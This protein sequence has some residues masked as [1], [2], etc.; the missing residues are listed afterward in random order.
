VGYVALATLKGRVATNLSDSHLDEI[1]ATESAAI[2]RALGVEPGSPMIE[3]FYGAGPVLFLTYDPDP[4]S[5]A[6][7]SI[8]DGVEATIDDDA[9]SV[10][11]T[12][13]VR[14]SALAVRSPLDPPVKWPRITR[15]TYA[16]AD[17]PGV[18]AV[19]QGVCIDLCRLAI[20]EMGVEQSESIGGYS[21]SSKDTNT[22]RRRILARL[23]RVKAS[24]PGV[25]R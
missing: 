8:A 20:N 18:L 2:T 9:Y 1:I 15:A 11:G 7:V 25:A 14:N 13:I 4:G 17:S 5:V 23:G 16:M 19:C 22:E 21:H 24:K 10:M 3:T 12:A 6:V